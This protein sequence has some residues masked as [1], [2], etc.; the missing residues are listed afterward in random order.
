VHHDRAATI[1]AHITVDRRRPLN[2]SVTANAAATD[3][4]SPSAVIDHLRKDKPACR[5]SS[6]PTMIADGPF[7]TPGEFAGF[8]GKNYDPLFLKDPNDPKFSVER[9]T[10]PTACRS[11]GWGSARDLLATRFAHRQAQQSGVVRPAAASVC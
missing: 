6:L 11:S 2:L 10:R 5:S 3:F 9:L 7:R 4:P 1:R 8:L